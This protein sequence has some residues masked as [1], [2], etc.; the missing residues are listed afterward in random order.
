VRS[1]VRGIL[2]RLGEFP[3]AR[4][5]FFHWDFLPPVKA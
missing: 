3:H 2:E 4:K 1:A 5:D